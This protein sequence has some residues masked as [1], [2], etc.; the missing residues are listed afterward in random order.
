MIPSSRGNESMF[1]YVITKERRQKYPWTYED[2][3]NRQRRAA[4]V[5]DQPRF[6]QKYLCSQSK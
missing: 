1:G 3:I 4:E 5:D 6:I 2:P